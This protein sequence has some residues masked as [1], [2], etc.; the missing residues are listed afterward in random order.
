MF[1][2]RDEDEKRFGMRI[3][4]GGAVPGN[5]L[6]IV[7]IPEVDVEAC[8]GTHLNNTFEAGMIKILKS[9]KISDSVVRIEYVSGDAAGE[10][11][12]R[13]EGI[14]GDVSEILGVDK[15]GVAI[16]AGEVFRFWK[17]IIKKKKSVEIKFSNEIESLNDK[18]ILEKTA[19]V[20]KT[21]VEHIPKTLKRFLKELDL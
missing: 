19:R 1:I 21:Q 12:N 6:R 20:L 10:E 9:S 13:E 3:Y 8:G 7:E 5:S 2:D 17:L 4:Q 11:V 15:K 16:R 18:E 14:L